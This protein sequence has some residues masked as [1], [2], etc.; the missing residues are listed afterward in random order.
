M[1]PTSLLS[2]ILLALPAVAY[3]SPSPALVAEEYWHLVP[4][5]VPFLFPRQD[6]QNLQIF[7]G[8]LGAA[9][10]ALVSCILS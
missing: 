8:T 1:L 6:G 7:T 2:F 9:A 5:G 3:G 4:R 10:P